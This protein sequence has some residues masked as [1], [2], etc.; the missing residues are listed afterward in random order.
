M[1]LARDRDLPYNEVQFTAKTTHICLAQ[2]RDLPSLINISLLPKA[3]HPSIHVH[4][5]A[6]GRVRKE[7]DRYRGG[8][9]GSRQ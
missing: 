3:E 6:D 7:A 1:F 8:G 9:S 4:T 2:A 5:V